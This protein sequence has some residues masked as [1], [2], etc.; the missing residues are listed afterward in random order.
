MISN[1]LLLCVCLF[2]VSWFSTAGEVVG[3]IDAEFEVDSR[4]NA[5]YTIPIEVP[6]GRL[7]MQPEITLEYNS[8]AGNGLVG[9]GWRLTGFSSITRVARSKRLDNYHG[10]VN[11]NGDDR[12]SMD[13]QRLILA[14]G[15]YGKDGS[16]YHT[17]IESWVKVTAHE[18]AGSGPKYFR[19]V[20]DNGEIFEFG[21]TSDSRLQVNIDGKSEIARW[22]LNK[23]TDRNGNT[24]IFSYY[25]DETRGD[26][27]PKEIRYTGLTGESERKVMFGYYGERTDTIQ[28]YTSGSFEKMEHLLKDIQTKIGNTKVKRYTLEYKQS[29][30]SELSLLQS[31][32]E[33]GSGDDVLPATVFTW[34]SGETGFD[35]D[36]Y[37]GKTR[38][39][40][41]SESG[42]VHWMVDMNNDGMTDYVYQKLSSRDLYVMWNE[43]GFLRTESWWGGRS[44]NWN[45]QDKQHW[46][47]DIDRDNEMDYLYEHDNSDDV[48]RTI[49]VDGNDKNDKWGEKKYPNRHK[50]GGVWVEDMDGDGL[51][52]YFYVH[53]DSSNFMH[54]LKNN[55]KQDGQSF[56]SYQRWGEAQTQDVNYGGYGNW[57]A[58]M[59][60]DGLPDYLFTVKNTQDYYVMINKPKWGEIE[61]KKW[62]NRGDGNP[63]WDGKYQ[64]DVDM[65]GDGLTDLMYGKDGTDEF[66]VMINTG[67]AFEPVKLWGAKSYR[68][69]EDVKGC[70]VADMNGDGY[71]DFVYR[72]KDNHYEYYVMLNNGR[73]FY[74]EIM[75]GKRNSNN[76]VGYS[77]NAQW[78]VDMTGDGMSDYIYERDKKQQYWVMRN[79]GKASRIVGIAN[80]LGATIDISYETPA[81]GNIYTIGSGAKHPT[82]DDLPSDHFVSQYKT[83][84]AE[85]GAQARTYKYHYR[86]MRSHVDHGSLGFEQVTVEDMEAGEKTTTTYH[87]DFPL[88]GLAKESKVLE[89]G[90]NETLS[91]TYYT[92]SSRE[93]SGIDDVHVVTLDEEKEET[94]HDNNSVYNRKVTLAY[95]AA[96]QNMVKKVD[97]GDS[98]VEGDEVYLHFHYGSQSGDD[99]WQSF[100]PTAV[101]TM[102]S[103]AACDWDEWVA[104]DDLN[105][106]KFSYDD[107]MNVT[108]EQLWNDTNDGFVK[109]EMDHDTYGNIVKYRIFPG[110]ESEG[111]ET[112][113]YETTVTFDDDAMFPIAVE[114]GGIAEQ[115]EFEP[116]FGVMTKITDANGNRLERRIDQFGELTE[117]RG[118]DP[119]GEMVVLSTEK[120]GESSDGLFYREWRF[121][122]DWED[123]DPADWVWEREYY[124]SLQRMVKSEYKGT[125]SQSVVMEIA[126]DDLGRREKTSY[127][128]FQDASNVLY[129]TQTYNSRGRPKDLTDGSGALI[130]S[131]SYSIPSKKVIRKSPTYGASNPD[132]GIEDNRYVSDSMNYNIQGSL[133]RRTR[134]STSG[135]AVTRF[136]PDRLQRMISVK[137]A[138]D[139]QATTT[140]NS[141]DQIVAQETP[142]TG[143]RTM[144]YDDAGRVNQV[145]DEAGQKVAFKY[146]NRNRL[147]EKRTYDANSELRQWVDYT[148]DSGTENANDLGLVSAIEGHNY[149]YSYTYDAYARVSGITLEMTIEDEPRTFNFSVTYNALGAPSSVT[150]PDGSRLLYSYFDNG[151]L[152][153]LDL[154]DG[155]SSVASATFA[156]YTVYHEAGTITLGNGVVNTRDWDELGRLIENKVANDSKV[157][158]HD[159]LIWNKANKLVE[160]VNLRE[161]LLTEIGEET[162]MSSVSYSYNTF[163]GLNAHFGDD[164]DGNEAWYF[165]FEYDKEANLQFRHDNTNDTYTLFDYDQ[166][167]KYTLA[168]RS[169]DDETTHFCYD[170]NG[171]MEAKQTGE[172]DHEFVYEP[173][174]LLSVVRE[175]G[176]PVQE[177]SYDYS[178]RR[179]KK[180]D[181]NGDDRVTSYYISPLYDITVF[182]EDGVT[183]ELHT[184]YVLGPNGVLA[185]VTTSAENLGNRDLV[186]GEAGSGAPDRE[187]VWYFHQDQISSVTLV[188]DQAGEPWSSVNYGAYG[189]INQERSFGTDNFRPKF[190]PGKEWDTKGEIYYYGA[191]YYDPASGRFLS[192][193]PAGQFSNPYAYAYSDPVNYVDPNGEFAC[194]G[195]CISLIVGATVGAITGAASAARAANDGERIWNWDWSAGSGTVRGLVGGAIR[196]GIFGALGAL[197]PGKTAD[198]FVFDQ[199]KLVGYEIGIGAVESLVM[200]RFEAK[201]SGDF[202][203]GS[204]LGSSL[205]AGLGGAIGSQIPSPL[206]DWVSGKIISGADNVGSRIGKARNRDSQDLWNFETDR[207]EDLSL[208]NYE[209]TLRGNVGTRNSLSAS[210]E[211]QATKQRKQGTVKYADIYHPTNP[212]A[213]ELRDLL[214]DADNISFFTTL[215]D[216]LIE[217]ALLRGEIKSLVSSALKPD[218]EDEEEEE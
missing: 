38:D 63:A 163:G 214:G 165:Y 218:R 72:N 116:H 21:N 161:D 95:D 154:K 169:T 82:F 60:N 112:I 68:I 115:R 36:H 207:L 194:A 2:S 215:R 27:R 26:T 166:D 110:G 28:G 217:A 7:G 33:E 87:Q 173:E 138:I 122:L 171:N 155:D 64:W 123:D 24:I 101:K 202:E 168:Q 148:Y 167:N 100:F 83:K 128:H 32:Q 131:L 73:E 109:R 53:D 139:I 190:A 164:A 179:I 23:I 88:I 174:N 39:H 29:D 145:I 135:D 204:Y 183:K 90:N 61:I 99:W 86:R 172:T 18:S 54:I 188:T 56:N 127:P 129:M 132:Q 55:N 175:N 48:R 46:F 57:V 17:E 158:L 35:T 37:E 58:E 151:A 31:I 43:D 22:T 111:D 180:D 152:K 149:K 157:Y 182:E 52:D 203:R 50:R 185:S 133:T 70:W 124:D 187:G 213:T 69:H 120:I 130:R 186:A 178:G 20:N 104:N 1:K 113:T 14:S 211:R 5:T 143:K 210:Q 9:P 209:R 62:G 191:R 121:R 74:A 114:A 106:K 125:G 16:V 81:Q 45:I 153:K 47:T 6:P 71:T 197:T 42:T 13:G 126:Y 159:A 11:Y 137:D 97:W 89:T 103:D 80:G 15:D 108:A 98:E 78:L 96:G 160:K 79:K 208:T 212:K 206:S 136:S 92:Y 102:Q 192:P 200:D 107:R 44:S 94:W 177:F 4:G 141:L 118:L 84:A 205:K 199:Q 65:N 91:V 19:A 181:L 25:E 170:E 198:G 77:N 12:F 49:R 147:T 85:S 162:L 146:D 93:N 134:I 51:R 140:Y 40:G 196:G 156:D 66:W 75:W 10:S 117:T 105:W 76:N 59:N 41:V 184:K 189:M 119:D 193:D 176:A 150:Y 195:V 8:S 201:L 30:T 34:D 216:E 3:T 67:L 144:T 142:E